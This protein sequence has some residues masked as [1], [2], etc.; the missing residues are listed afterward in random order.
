MTAS[1]AA[2]GAAADGRYPLVE[3]ARPTSTIVRAELT[4]VDHPSTAMPPHVLAADHSLMPE[5]GPT[6]GEPTTAAHHAHDESGEAGFTV[7]EVIVAAVVL[8][9]GMFGV[10]TML[11]GVVATTSAN[12]DRVGATNLARELVETARGLDYDDLTP[13]L[14]ASRVQARGLGTGTP[15]TI[16]RRGVTYTITSAACVFDSPADQLATSAPADACPSQPAGSTG[17]RNGDDFRRVTFDVAWTARGIPRSLSQSELIV[18]PSGGLGPR[19]TNVSPLTQTITSATAAPASVRFTT[20][21]AASVHWHADDGKSEADA[22]GPT[23]T[24]QTWT[25]NWAISTAVDGSYQMIAQ[26]F[27]DRGI[28]GDAKLA[29]IVLNRY[30]PAA[31]LPSAPAPAFTG[32]RNTRLGIVELSWKLNAERDILGY[33]VYWAGPDGIGNG[34]DDRVCPGSGSTASMLANTTSSCSDLD[35][36]DSGATVYYVVAVDRDPAGNLREGAPLIVPIAAASAPP[37]FVG[38]TLSALIDDG[39]LTLAWGAPLTG[40]VSFY[41]IYRDGVAYADRHDRTTDS[42]R[43]WSEASTAGTHQYWITA[44]DSNYNESLPIGPVS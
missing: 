13:A 29:S 43:S 16:E 28:A 7:I 4:A 18:N 9:V 38:V 17:D 37:L 22:T 25:A 31:P 30:E 8:L 5:S 26:A 39:K 6:R 34:N 42:V 35:P 14:L 11:D 36:R 23:G 40:S 20:T 32:G 3:V 41:R 19:I 27:D 10:L 44:V 15:W 2:S 1:A 24:P 33:R 12:N 21:P